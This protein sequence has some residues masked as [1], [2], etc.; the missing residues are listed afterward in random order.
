ML[1]GKRDLKF[2]FLTLFFQ[3]RFPRVPLPKVETANLERQHLQSPRR[4]KEEKRTNNPIRRKRNRVEKNEFLHPNASQYFIINQTK[5][6]PPLT[7]SPPTHYLI[8][9]FFLVCASTGKLLKWRHT[10]YKSIEQFLGTP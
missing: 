10:T 8:I 5:Q 9:P 1:P 3:P 7:E 6:I 2:I 4:E